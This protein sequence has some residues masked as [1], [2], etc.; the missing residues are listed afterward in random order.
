MNEKWLFSFFGGA[1]SKDNTDGQLERQN[2]EHVYD[3]FF[4][5]KQ[6]HFSLVSMIMYLFEKHSQ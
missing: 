6:T 5:E 1:V 4:K 2:I 3:S